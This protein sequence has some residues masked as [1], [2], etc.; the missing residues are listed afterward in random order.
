MFMR[1]IWLAAALLWGAASGHEIR[2]AQQ[3][4]FGG[5]LKL[6]F[7]VTYLDPWGHTVADAT[8]L[9]YYHDRISALYNISPVL[10]SHEA[11]ILPAKYWGTYPLFYAGRTMSYRIRLTNLGHKK[12]KK[13]RVVAIQEYLTPDGTVGE[14]IGPDAVR[15]WYIRKLG[16]GETI[17]LDGAIAIPIFGVR[18]GLD[19]THIQVF[20][21]KEEPPGHRRHHEDE[22]DDDEDAEEED[23][24]D[25]EFLRRHDHSHEALQKRNRLLFEDIQAGIWCPPAF[26][27]SPR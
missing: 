24:E 3:K 9:H 16:R 15:D 11:K 1:H 25:R 18:S 7:E 5:G 21:H 10:V 8:G 17:Y 23:A 22:E 2:K 4:D 13:A 12:L 14:R 27:P 20:R 6:Q 19:Q 26:Q